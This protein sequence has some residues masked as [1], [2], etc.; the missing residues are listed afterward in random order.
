LTDYITFN[1][2]LNARFLDRQSPLATLIGSYRTDTLMWF[3]YVLGLAFFS[4]TSKQKLLSFVSLGLLVSVFLMRKPHQQYLMMLIPLAAAISSGTLHAIFRE[5]KMR[6]VVLILSIILPSY[7]LFSGVHQLDN[8]EQIRKINY[9]LSITDPQDFVYDGNIL[10]NIYRKDL[11]FFWYSLDQGDGLATYQSMTKYDYN[12]YELIEKFKP[13]VISNYF[14]NNMNDKRIMN[15]YKQS[16]DYPDLYLR[17][18][19]EPLME[20]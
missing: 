12:I 6:L 1:W 15:H 18:D 5:Q 2:T 13:K 8:S 9:V 19:P 16:M 10:F 14:I 20:R 7:V 11:D 17:L 3:F 4:K